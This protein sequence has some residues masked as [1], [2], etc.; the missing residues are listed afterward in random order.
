V[1]GA[2]AGLGEQRLD[3]EPTG[4]L[5]PGELASEFEGL[6]VTALDRSVADAPLADAFEDDGGA[7]VVAAQVEFEAMVHPIAAAGLLLG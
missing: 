2:G 4:G 3:T 6:E 5:I 7:V 1:R